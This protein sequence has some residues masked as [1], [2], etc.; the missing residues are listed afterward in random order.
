[1]NINTS[2]DLEFE[3]SKSKTI[4]SIT[5]SIHNP[6]Q[7]LSSVDDASA[8]IY[9]I[10]RQLPNNRFNIVQQILQDNKNNK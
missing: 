3:F 9:K 7:E 2:P 8:I 10:T 4:T 1:M 6:T 5:T